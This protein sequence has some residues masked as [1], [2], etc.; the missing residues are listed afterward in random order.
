MAHRIHISDTSSI[1]VDTL[2]LADK[3]GTGPCTVQPPSGTS[4][5]M[6]GLRQGYSNIT[7]NRT[8]GLHESNY[9]WTNSGASSLTMTL[10]SGALE[11]FS[12]WLVRTGGAIT[13]NPTSVG[14]IWNTSNGTFRSVG[15]T[16]EMA[17]SGCKLK[18]I[19]DGSDGW[20]PT[21]EE[22]TIS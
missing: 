21:L 19:C 13:V 6:L 12:V 8:I 22:G 3:S 11:G 10:P 4:I 17:S 9:V 14:R 18:L 16:V 20:Y 7:S 15:T 2:V 1:S 5:Q